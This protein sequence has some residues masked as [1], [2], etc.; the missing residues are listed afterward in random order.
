ME[1]FP[2]YHFTQSQPQ[3]YEYVRQDYPELF[4][5]IKARVAEGR[6]EIMG[7][8]W[9]E[10]DCNFSGPESLA[11]QFCSGA[12]TSESI[13]ARARVGR[14]MAAGRIRLRLEP[15]AID[16]AGGPGVLLHDQD[17]LE[18]VQPPAL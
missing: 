14:A 16:Q 8:M 6:W 7:D 18:P 2:D 12:R 15:A 11:R 1:Q 3:L 4:A 17:R 10:A 9:V 5:A 13:S